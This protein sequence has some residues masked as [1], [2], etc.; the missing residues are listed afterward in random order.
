MQAAE[1][2]KLTSPLDKNRTPTP[3]RSQSHSKMAVFKT[4]YKPIDDHC[5]PSR[6]DSET[7]AMINDFR[8]L[9]L[10]EYYNIMKL[11]DEQGVILS[12]KLVDRGM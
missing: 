4:G 2:R 7:G 10:K 8:Q 6:L 3:S 9:K 12:R 5:R 11:C 1:N